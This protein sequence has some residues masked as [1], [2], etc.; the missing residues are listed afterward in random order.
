MLLKQRSIN[1]ISLLSLCSTLGNDSPSPTT[2]QLGSVLNRPLISSQ[3]WQHLQQHINFLSLRLSGDHG[4]IST[5]QWPVDFIDGVSVRCFSSIL[6]AF[7]FDAHVV[8]ADLP[9]CT[10]KAPN[11]LCCTSAPVP[12]TNPTSPQSPLLH[13]HYFPSYFQVFLLPQVDASWLNW[14]QRQPS[15]CMKV[16]YLRLYILTTTQTLSTLRRLHLSSSCFHTNLSLK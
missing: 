9:G 6:F 3:L 15:W 16:S 11:P 14:I 7:W 10:S 12:S 1:S 4:Y 2:L 13:P 5:L 8:I